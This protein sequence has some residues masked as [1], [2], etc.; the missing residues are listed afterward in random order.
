MNAILK[1]HVLQIF[2]YWD[3]L[4]FRIRAEIIILF[5]IFYSFFTDKLVF[6]FNQILDQ[7][8]TSLTGLSTIVLHL[9]MLI[10]ILSTPFI[11]FN[12]F[13]R[14]K[15]LTNLS[16]YP[17]KKSEALTALMIYFVKYQIVIILIA[18]PVFTALTLS[19][20]PL[21]L[22]Y[23]LFLS[24][25]SLF[26]SALLVLILASKYLSRS[27]IF[28]QYFLYFFLY[29][30][31][32]AIVYWKT[33][34][35]FYYTILVIFC[36]WIVLL[37]FWNARWQSWDQILNR[38][39]PVVQKST[40]NM[41]KLTYFQFPSTVPKTLRPLFIKEILS[42]IRNK[43]YMRL[44]IISLFI[45]LIIMILVD[46]FYH[47]YFTTV[48]SLLT[49]LLIWEH[50]SN[51]FNEKYVMKESRFFIKVLPIK[52]YQYSLSKFF[53]E[54]LYIALILFVVLILTLIHGT[55]LFKILNILGIIT[56]FS[57]FVL[58]I[59]TL[60]RVIFYDNP[61]VAGY[62][63]HFLIIFTI[64]MSFNFYLV[65]PIVTLFII[66]YLHFISNRQFAR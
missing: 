22:L 65:G 12:L 23:I 52:F 8:D 53:S 29:F 59:I 34:L 45:Y 63:Y 31:S 33:Y 39:R 17:L 61:R 51:Q 66:I 64:V 14:Q 21:M 1:Y 20:G 18:T 5:V 62:A 37:R 7:Q 10:V 26:H 19:T 35:F 27:R 55:A 49:I 16:L 32:F 11:Y 60:I 47:E 3:H 48:I 50:Y 13:P 15:G 58:Y 2:N 25:S 42:H 41:S 46:I 54:F 57:L 44:K 24:C 9:L 30:G 36:G 43:N 6:Y 38:Y 40:Q 56:I 4:K 28:F